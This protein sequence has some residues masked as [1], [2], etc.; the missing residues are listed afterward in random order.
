MSKLP[1]PKTITSKDT[2]RPFHNPRNIPKPKTVTPN[3]TVGSGHSDAQQKKLLEEKRV[4][5]SHQREKQK[6]NKSARPASIRSSSVR[7]MSR[8]RAISEPVASAKGVI[9]R[10]KK[11][12]HSF[13]SSRFSVSKLNS[14]DH[15]LN[16]KSTLNLNVKMPSF[17]S[18]NRSLSGFKM[19]KMKSFSSSSRKKRRTSLKVP[20]MNFKF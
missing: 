19:P 14:V 1:V 20:N 11:L 9:D 2:R 17:K 3:D 18:T 5:E 7:P 8:S 4:L 16:R 13:D 6:M 10:F 12:E 15:K